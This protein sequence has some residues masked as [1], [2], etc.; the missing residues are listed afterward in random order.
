MLGLVPCGKRLREVYLFSLE[1]KRFQYDLTA[2]FQCLQGGYQEGGGSLFTEVHGGRIRGHTHKWEQDGFQLGMRKNF[3]HEDSLASEQ[4]AQRVCTGS[5]LVVFKKY[6][7]P[8]LSPW[9]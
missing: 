5:V 6:L 4:V 9:V 2:A 3:P 1:K 8:A 7:D